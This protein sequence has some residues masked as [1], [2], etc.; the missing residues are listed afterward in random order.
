MTSDKKKQVLFISSLLIIIT[1][2]HYFTSNNEFKLHELYRRLY[3]IPIIVGA[4]YFKLLG[5]MILP[6]VISLLYMP[7]VFIFSGHTGADLIADV[8]ELIM[9][10]TIGG[11][12]GLLVQ[13]I[14]DTT[15]ENSRL[16]EEIQ[17]A[18]KLSAIGQLASGV[19]HEI[20][21]PLAIINTI[22]QTLMED[23]HLKQD[24]KE[25]LEIIK[26]EVARSNKVINELLNFS[27]SSKLEKEKIDI[28]KL[29]NNVVILTEKYGAQK[30]VEIQFKQGNNS[31]A[32]IMGDEEKIKQAFIN[33]IFNGVDA[34][35]N[36]GVIGIELTSKEKF[37][38][39]EFE[40][41]GKGIEEENIEKIFNPFYTTKETGVGLGLAITY[42]IVEDHKGTINFISAINRG[43][44]VTVTFPRAKE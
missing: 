4:F 22:S 17:R 35:Q 41:T 20:R 7:Y 34:I 5:G 24:Q 9:F 38:Y 1:A 19:A 32:F 33:I 37:V 29:I 16:E 21:N 44:K 28:N 26:E 42:R 8:F 30:G 13:K 23:N 11:I 14:Y 6:I 10:Y 18:D 3:Y 25:G 2:L 43:T 36:K 12:T 27:R 15:L 31:P 40:D 39:I